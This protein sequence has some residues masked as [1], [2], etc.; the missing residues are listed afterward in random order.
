[1]FILFGSRLYKNSRRTGIKEMEYAKY[2]NCYRY[3][4]VQETGARPPT[5][6][7]QHSEQGGESVGTNPRAEGIDLLLVKPVDS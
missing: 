2:K 7:V 5:L 6:R 1:V 3:F 4:N